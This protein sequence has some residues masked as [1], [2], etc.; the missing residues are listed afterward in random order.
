[1]TQEELSVM[2][3]LQENPEASFARRE[4]AKKAVKRRIYEANP[5]WADQPLVA[6]V[7]RGLVIIDDSA[8]YRIKKSEAFN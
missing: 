6:L 1:M 4:I 8:F 2:L 3:F 7:S 5:H